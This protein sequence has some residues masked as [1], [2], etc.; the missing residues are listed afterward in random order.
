MFCILRNDSSTDLLPPELYHWHMYLQCIY[1]LRLT[2]P[3]LHLQW[4]TKRCSQKRVF[5]GFDRIGWFAAS[6]MGWSA[7]NFTDILFKTWRTHLWHRSWGDMTRTSRIHQNTLEEGDFDRLWSSP[8][9]ADLA[10]SGNI[11]GRLQYSSS[12]SLSLASLLSSSWASKS[13]EKVRD[14]WGDARKIYSPQETAQ[15][16]L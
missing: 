1:R 10:Q 6:G 4:D 3:C 7:S 14:M 9:A 13:L 16:S 2:D 5:V 11:L 8:I 12:P 15:N